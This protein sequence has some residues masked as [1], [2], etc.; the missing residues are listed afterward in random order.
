MI[1]PPDLT[2]DLTPPDPLR[3]FLGSVVPDNVHLFA[4]RFESCRDLLIH[5]AINERMET[6]KLRGERNPLFADFVARLSEHES[7]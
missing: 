6:D 1:F 5:Y 4:E 7:P 3:R 2:R